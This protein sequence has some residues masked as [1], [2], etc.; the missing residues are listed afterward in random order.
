MRKKPHLVSFSVN[1]DIIPA[2]SL[3]LLTH[4][5]VRFAHSPFAYIIARL[6]LTCVVNKNVKRFKLPCI[7][8]H[9]IKFH[10]N[11]RSISA[12]PAGRRSPQQR[13][14]QVRQAEIRTVP[15]L[16]LRPKL[17]N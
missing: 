13:T 3:A 10:C 5:L 7:F 15:I 14:S 9:L 8:S 11:C 4:R 1:S 16:N 12:K 6:R 17:S 2:R